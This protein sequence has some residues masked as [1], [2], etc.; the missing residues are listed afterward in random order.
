M[1]NEAEKNRNPGKKSYRKF[2]FFSIYIRK[3][4]KGTAVR[5]VLFRLMC[6]GI[7]WNLATNFRIYN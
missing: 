3:Q 6:P 5:L 1:P 7:N 4:K 2:L